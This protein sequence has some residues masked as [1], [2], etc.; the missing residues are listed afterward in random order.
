MKRKWWVIPLSLMACNY[1]S[2]VA[3]PN[4]LDTDIK[5]TTV[6]QE[7]VSG[8]VTDAGNS[9][10]LAGVTVK[11]K[12]KDIAT[13]TGQDG[14]YSISASIGQK[15]EVSYLGYDIAEQTVTSSTLNFKLTNEASS[16]EEVVVVGYGTQS[17]REITSA[18]ASVKEKDFNSGGMRNPMELVQGKVAG[19]NITSPQGSN[20]N[21]GTNIQL[22]G[23]ASLKGTNSPLIVIDGI[24]GGSLDLIKQG[25]IESIDVLKDGSAAAIYGTRGNGGVIL[26]T[27]KKGKSGI[28]MFEYYTYAQKEMVNRKPSMLSA[29]QFREYIVKGMDKPDLD[30]GSSTEL[31]DELINKDNFSHFH[32]FVASGG[33]EKSTYRAAINYELAEGV[34]KASSRDQF[35]G[36]FNFTQTGLKDRLTMSTNVAANFIKSDLLGGGINNDFTSVDYGKTTGGDFEQAIQRNP[37]APIMNPDGSFYETQGYNN[38][39]PI[40]RLANRIF[41][42]NQQTF[43]GDTKLRLQ[44][45]DQLSVSAFGSYV[46]QNFND[47]MYR[48][49]NDWD[50]RL[51]STYRGM[52]YAA[53]RNELAW[54]KTFESTIDYHQTFNDR[55]KVTGLLGY[56]Y[57]YSTLERFNMANNGFTTDGFLDWNMGAGNA[58]IDDTLPRPSMGSFKEDNTLIAFFGRVNYNLDDKYFLTAILRREGS[59]RFGANHKWGNFP[60]V[61][62]GWNITN[63]S[64]FANKAIVSNLKLRAGYGVTGN[65]G[66]PNYQSILQLST[67]GVYPIIG[68][69]YNQTYGPSVNPNPN[70]KWEQ[71]AETN[72]GVDFGFLNNRI[73]GSL[74]VYNRNTTDL[75][76]DYLAQQPSYTK[77]RIWYNVGSVNNKGVELQLSAAAISK[78]DFIWNIDF[79][80]NYQKN[81]LTKLSSDV[82][83]S[84]WIPFGGLPSPGNLGDAIRL[85]EGGEIGAFFGKRYAGLTDDGKWLFYKA[86][87]SAA[88]TSEINNDDLTYIGNGI[89]KFQASLSNRFS[90]KGFDLTVFLR[91]KFKYNILNTADMFF[92]NK[93]WVPN[94]VLESAF[95]THAK[96]DDNPQYSDYYLENGSFVKLDNITLGYTVNTKT[97]YI[98]NLYVYV[99]GRNIATMT[100]YSGVDPELQDTGF[101]GGI[102]SRGFYPRTQSWSIGLN[103]GF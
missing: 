78:A 24:P 95:T 8:I 51:N 75:I 4:I 101:D 86:D 81:I 99:T 26:V 10:P 60:A 69:E 59:S 35:G 6:L 3:A 43:S 30:L 103:I 20:P 48:S 47:R 82:F 22:R 85:E 70:L 14:R 9:Q 64:F 5:E 87:G 88:P 61:S 56:S 58:L 92:G 2:V 21:G 11:V 41:E 19:L 91:G 84:N 40:A 74:D 42:R 53:K 13:Q 71:K 73:T 16:L 45:I 77:D 57:Q 12:G 94:N 25:D 98:R 93:K 72:I 97:D 90:Y 33:G 79:T 96:L 28:P 17:R 31:Y 83:K 55:H 44:I 1:G 18:V 27:T 46:R 34:A 63:E 89:P 102:D 80:G 76:F 50:Q 36:R 52:A 39:N 62:A 38:Y 23:M 7:S 37:T 49:I 65:Q 15:L 68:G 32:N 54:S 66:I 100:G 29:D 67:G